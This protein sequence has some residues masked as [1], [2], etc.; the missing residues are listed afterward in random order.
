M[1]IRSW[2]YVQIILPTF[3]A[4][5]LLVT[6][7]FFVILPFV[8][9]TLL[10]RKKELM[11]EEVA[12]AFSVL[13]DLHYRA[14]AGEMS[15][16][17][18]KAQ[19]LERLRKL[20]YGPEA[21][22]YFW[23]TDTRPAMLMHPYRPDLEG[24]DLTEFRDAA[25]KRLF[26]DIL[27][28]VRERGEGYAGYM[29]Q[30]KDD[31]D[32]IG[33]KLSF[34]R[35][36]D[37]W[38]FIV[39]TGV[40][41]DDVKQEIGRIMRRM[42][43]VLTGI[44]G[45]IGFLLLY[46]THRSL[47]IE[48]E[49]SAYERNL[50]ESRERYKA[51]LESTTEGVMLV[52]DGR[53]VY[54]N[55]TLLQ[56]LGYGEDEFASLDPEAL[57]AETSQES[58]VGRRF[59]LDMLSG[60]DHPPQFEAVLRR[61]DGRPLDAAL[62]CSP[63]SVGESP[64]VSVSVRDVSAH[65]AMAE[66]Y[67]QSLAAF[68]FLA[69]NINVGVLRL[70]TGRGGRVVEANAAARTI[71]GRD[72]GESLAGLALEELFPR[73]PGE[74]DLLA[75][76]IEAGSV[77]GRIVSCVTPGGMDKTISLSGVAEL[78]GKGFASF[79]NLVIEDVTGRAL[80]DRARSQLIAELQ[81]ALGFLNLPVS[82]L[83]R[84]L[85][86]VDP[87]LSVR[88][89]AA[90]MAG[91]GVG[92]L[93]V[94]GPGG[95]LAGVVTPG[96]VS[97]KA[98]AGAAGADSGLGASDA[99]GRADAAGRLGGDAP[100]SSIMSRSPVTLPASAMVFEAAQ[101]MADKNIGHLALTDGEGRAFGLV[102]SADL[103]LSQR[104]SLAGLA[105]TVRRASRPEEVF[106][107]RPG[108]E[109]LIL[110]MI[111]ARAGA[112]VTTRILASIS[113]AITQG[114]ARMGVERLG[115][116]PARFEFLSMG[117]QGRFE[118]TLSTDQDNAILF[119]DVEPGREA[120]ARS[121]FQELGKLVC[122]WLDQAG[123][124]FCEGGVMAQNPMWCM[125]LTQW[126]QSFAGW[127]NEG[128]PQ[129]LL[130]TKI[131]FDFRCVYGTGRM[132]AE[133]RAF[134]DELLEGNSIFFFNLAQNCLLFKPPLGLFKTI[135]T[136]DIGSRGKGLSLK[137]AMTPIV[138]F[139]RVYALKHRVHATNTLERL[140][141][142]REGGHLGETAARE[143]EQNYA[144]LM[145]QRLRAQTRSIRETGRPVNT[146]DPKGLTSLDMAM[147]KEAFSQIALYQKKMNIDFMGGA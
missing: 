84:P 52:M 27:G 2:F 28:S 127:V 42:A 62:L 103:L 124:A 100:V 71:L 61:K 114:F 26:V 76:I 7:V 109:A 112:G 16:E 89:A 144:S 11:R 46:L 146:V 117:S 81:T 64:G 67:G 13:N 8:E 56:M 79:V 99:G 29:W 141:L 104:Y 22:D 55:R 20:R 102:E 98:M 136:E 57:F 66:R 12:T 10:D 93:A 51:L 131:F 19:A 70:S 63:M 123:Y 73:A 17:E 126:K 41:V 108:L 95:A 53:F 83:A 40:Y 106:G 23:V 58:Y 68:E 132:A 74:P 137:K 32:K 43:W 77:K 116:P 82:G 9:E 65:K 134:L 129:D 37:P 120:E 142:L 33:S 119:E 78:D 90:L 69:E 92:I 86:F 107:A 125:P 72:G 1:R 139:A 121:Y 145:E 88:E 60:R 111:D 94:E 87:S 24:S 15:Q 21:K 5:A 44:T 128:T 122:G 39:G 110:A 130:N 113:D 138:D 14:L 118:Q 135:R 54:A 3:L 147:L 85:R 6:S 49:R 4:L 50:M 115:V 36:F 96:D 34:V 75:A 47:Q 18:A 101:L 45:L 59:F 25:G 143:L 31:A 97:G 35:R 140:S 80:A 38:G 48:H 105:H 30:W 133:L 91:E